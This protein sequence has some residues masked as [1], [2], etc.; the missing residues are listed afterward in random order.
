MSFVLKQR[1][2]ELVNERSKIELFRDMCRVKLARD[3]S[4]VEFNICEDELSKITGIPMGQLVCGSLL[5]KC[6]AVQKLKDQVDE[7]YQLASDMLQCCHCLDVSSVPLPDAIFGPDRPTFLDELEVSVLQGIAEVARLRELLVLARPDLLPENTLY[8]LPSVLMLQKELFTIE[9]RVKTLTE[10]TRLLGQL[11]TSLYHKHPKDIS[12]FLEKQTELRVQRSQLVDLLDRVLSD[13][14]VLQ[15][16]VYSLERDSAQVRPVKAALVPLLGTFEMRHDIFKSMIPALQTFTASVQKQGQKDMADAAELLLAYRRC[17]GVVTA[18]PLAQGNGH[19]ISGEDRTAGESLTADKIL[20]EIQD[21]D[22][23]L[24]RAQNEL[25]AMSEQVATQAMEQSKSAMPDPQS[26]AFRLSNQCKQMEEKIQQTTALGSDMHRRAQEA[27]YSRLLAEEAWKQDMLSEIQLRQDV[28]SS[29]TELKH[30]QDKPSPAEHTP[31]SASGLE[32]YIPRMDKRHPQNSPSCLSN[33]CPHSPSP[34]YIGQSD[35]PPYKTDKVVTNAEHLQYQA[36]IEV[37]R[38][39]KIRRIH[40]TSLPRYIPSHSQRPYHS[41]NLRLRGDVTTT[42]LSKPE[43]ESSDGS[44][45]QSLHDVCMM[46]VG[47]MHDDQNPEACGS[48]LPGKR[49][50]EVQGRETFGNDLDLDM[51]SDIRVT[52]P[53]LPLSPSVS[54]SAVG[55]PF[56]CDLQQQQGALE[57]SPCLRMDLTSENTPLNELEWDLLSEGVL[58]ETGSDS[59]DEGWEVLEN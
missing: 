18:L 22:V 53:G 58:G 56:L 5:H 1:R 21:F 48:S 47:S 37:Q 32:L 43:A 44:V 35:Q 7:R 13:R 33:K 14:E 16:Q 57:N 4:V 36:P 34:N 59:G 40:G 27:V 6:E 30:L 38:A 26:L 15:R 9:T 11:V 45:M 17:C 24:H 52:Q 23:R 10:E 20:G 19:N 46:E 49:I 12:E 29:Q 3:K 51:N 8:K 42:Q 28:L 41:N 39:L 25:R 54:L 55:M 2:E 31:S 50:D